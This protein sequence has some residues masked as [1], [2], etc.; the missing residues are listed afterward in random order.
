MLL[1][2][3]NLSKESTPQRELW[4]R[5]GKGKKINLKSNKSNEEPKGNGLQEKVKIPKYG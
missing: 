5:G 4:E 1:P 2:S 3:G